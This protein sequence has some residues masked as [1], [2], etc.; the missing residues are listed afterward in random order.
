MWQW[1][2]GNDIVEIRGKKIVAIG[3]CQ[4]HYWNRR[5]KKKKNCLIFGNGI[6]EIG[7]WR[8]ERER[9]SCLNKRKYST[10][11]LIPCWSNF[12]DL[13]YVYVMFLPCIVS[14]ESINQSPHLL[15]LILCLEYI[16]W[17]FPIKPPID[18][19]PKSISDILFLSF[20]FFSL[21]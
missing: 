7:N 13:F 5:K 10:N 14:E 21:S 19:M 9:E 12:L 2:C 6:A 1:I 17:S 15:I 4:W 18:I 3:L 20:Y 11:I 8:R 16:Y